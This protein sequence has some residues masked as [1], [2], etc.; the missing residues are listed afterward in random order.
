MNEDFINQITI[1][2]TEPAYCKTSDEQPNYLVIENPII[3]NWDEWGASLIAHFFKESSVALLEMEED[4]E[5]EPTDEK[6]EQG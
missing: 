4:P 3:K 5:I 6:D 2:N 1:W